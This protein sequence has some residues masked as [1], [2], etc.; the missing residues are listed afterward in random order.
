MLGPPRRVRFPAGEHVS[1]L[2]LK[3]GV[4]EALDTSRMLDEAI[5]QMAEFPQ[6]SH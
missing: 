6:R 2:G 3:K 5:H 4:M 1:H